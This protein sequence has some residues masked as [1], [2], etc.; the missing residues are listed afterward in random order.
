ML[1]RAIFLVLIAA[2]W[3]CAVAQNVAAVLTNAQARGAFDVRHFGAKGDGQTDDQQAIV[4]AAAAAVE[5][6]GG[7]VYFPPGRYVHSG[8]LDFG[9]GVVIEGAGQATVLQGTNYSNAALRFSGTPG[10]GV[11]NVTVA[12]DATARLTNYESADIFLDGATDCAIAGVRIDGSAS[13]GIVIHNSSNVTVIDNEVRNTL[14]DGIHTVGGS[15]QVLVANNQSWNT[16]DDSFSAVAYATEPQTYGVTISN[17]V[18]VNSHARGVSCVGASGCVISG[19]H[20]YNPAA[21][22]I[23]IAYESSWNTWVPSGAVASGNVI[24]GVTNSGFNPLIVDGANNISIGVNDVYNSTPVLLHA[25]QNVTVQGLRVHN[26]L[27]VGVLGENC[28]ALALQSVEIDTAAQSGIMLQN[29]NQGEISNAMLDN[30]QTTGDPGRGAIDA[31]LCSPLNGTGNVVQHNG[32]WRGQ[33]F[34][35]SRLPQCSGT[36]TVAAEF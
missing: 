23:D 11:F 17:N 4:S 33:S 25:S 8:I 28:S 7:V 1:N 35:A 18:S 9:A 14:A 32:N 21:H 26:A 27:S 6:G 20:V 19:N 2:C 31:W 13:A 36:L 34:G 15:H 30:V 16:G 5:K 29:V 3:P 10:C 24:V 22:G 12:S